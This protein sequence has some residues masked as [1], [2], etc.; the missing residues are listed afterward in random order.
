ME[1][2]SNA[3][4]QRTIFVCQGTGCTS[5]KSEEITA[6]LRKAV[7]EAGL[8]DVKV[9]F[10]GCQEFC[11]MGPVALVE[12]DGIFYVHVSVDDVPEIVNSHLR[13][14]KPVERLYYTDPVTNRPVPKYDDI[15][16]N[17]LQ[18]RVILRNCGHINPERIQDYIDQ[19][20]YQGLRK[21][22]KMTPEEVIAEVK[23]SGLRGRGGAGFSTGL[24]WEL[25][26]NNKSDQKYMICNADEGDPGAFMDSA[27]MEGD[28]HTVIGGMII[29]AYAIGA[30]Q[31]YIY[32]RAEYPLAIKRLT[33]ALKQAEEHGFLGDNILGSG[34]NFHLRIKKGAGAFV[35]GEETA[36]MASIE[37][38]R[39]MPRSRP[40][41]PAAYGLHGKPTTI[42]N[43]KTLATIP[44][45]IYKGADW[46]AAIGTE[47]SKGTAVFALTGKIVNGGLVE[48]PMG[49]KLRTIIYDIGG[50][51]PKG[52]K[53][54][55]VQTGGPSGGC[56]PADFLDS[57]VDYE[58]LAKAGSIV[59]SG[60]MVVMDEDTCMVDVARYFSAFTQS[61]SCGK[62]VPCRIGTRQ[63]LEI[64][65]RICRGQGKPEDIPT[66]QKLANDIK[67]GALCALGGTAPNPVL[68]TLR[69]FLDEYKAHI[70]E[71][72]CPG[73][74]CPD[75]IQFYVLPDK[76]QG[77]GICAREC[78]SG[79]IQGGKRMVH[80]IDQSKCGKC[81]VCIESCP[82]KFSA[83]VRV[84]GQKIDVPDQPIPVK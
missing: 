82:E 57:P 40:P 69:Y 12:P 13:D 34:F 77:C 79:A 55:A 2:K 32:I 28:P 72:R 11:E 44:A 62:C 14:G 18:N 35:C 22:L 31:G 9:D 23:K 33:I 19:G 50:G 3:F 49:T 45:I 70:E 39:G 20:G 29:A 21:A 4:N 26:R 76:C 36:M 52:K 61:E 46:Y 83:I 10:T 41:F 56:L 37:G 25:C 73:L 43:V 24:K 67:S 54:K 71:K 59:G 58:T 1:L 15:T 16:F 78:P 27:T 30:S 48:V 74:V 5:G 6:A 17:K 47:K 42:N 80:V 63:M 84:S 75:L 51:I 38:K 7:T 81:G 53:F 65:R 66:L 8:T 64:L 68:T 60:G